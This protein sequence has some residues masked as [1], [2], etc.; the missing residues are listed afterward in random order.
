MSRDRDWLSMSRDR[1][2]GSLYDYA[3]AQQGTSMHQ[4]EMSGTYLAWS[5]HILCNQK[6]D[7]PYGNHIL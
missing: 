2:T 1:D 5:N 3:R 6:H 4:L 7:V